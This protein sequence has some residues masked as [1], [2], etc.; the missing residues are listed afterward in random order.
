MD[1]LRF[2]T[3][4]RRLLPEF[5]FSR[6]TCCRTDGS[7]RNGVMPIVIQDS[8]TGKYAAPKGRWTRSLAKALRF[9][10]VL[11]AWDEIGERGLRGVHIL[12]WPPRRQSGVLL[13]RV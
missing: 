10:Q 1:P 4:S 7:A 11:R 2:F 8:T 6:A 9:E 3:A 5:R 12:F 13:E